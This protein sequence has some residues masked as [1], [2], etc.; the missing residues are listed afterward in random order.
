MATYRC[1]RCGATDETRRWLCKPELIVQKKD[2]RGIPIP[3]GQELKNLKA[4]AKRAVAKALKERAEH[5]EM[6]RQIKGVIRRANNNKRLRPVEKKAEAV[7]LDRVPVM[8]FAQDNG[9]ES[10]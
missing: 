5:A 9:E 4:R 10:S 3:T 8:A 6:E 1:T 7:V 2:E